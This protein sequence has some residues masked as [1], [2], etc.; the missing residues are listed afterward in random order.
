M[1]CTHTC[2]RL[3]LFLGCA[4]GALLSSCSSTASSA[5][6]VPQRIEIER[7]HEATVSIAATGAES[8]L[9][10][11]SPIPGDTLA[12]ALEEALLATQL[13]T[14]VLPEAGDYLLEVVILDVELPKAALDME[15][16]VTSEWTLT[17]RS[18]GG[19]VWKATITGKSISSVH[20]EMWVDDRKRAALEGAVRE[21]L[22]KG[23][24]HLAQLQL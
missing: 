18:T 13:F 8:G 10:S 7:H 12:S 6:M 11:S 19:K 1:T 24:V 2:L 15:A 14:E 22:S 5:G 21:S 23:L 16:E 4:L 9:L 20:Q 17:R 3:S